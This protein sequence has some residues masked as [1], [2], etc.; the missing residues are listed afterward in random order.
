M[1]VRTNDHQRVGGKQYFE[2]E[3]QSDALVSNYIRWAT[4]DWD[5]MTLSSIDDTTTDSGFTMADG[6]F[7]ESLWDG[8]GA[9][10]IVLP[11]AIPGALTAFRFVEQ[12]DGGATITFT[13]ATGDFYAA[14]SLIIPVTN[15]G[16]GLTDQRKVIL[17]HSW[18]P[19]VVNHTG[20]AT[21]TLTAAHNRFSIA[22]TATNNQTE[23]GATLGFY[24][25]E[26]GYW[27][28]SFLGSELGDGSINAT[29]AGSTV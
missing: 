24:C 18:T 19:T 2:H 10:A 11:E 16:D 13:T 14:Q 1:G 5:G 22:A 29:F 25:Q 15:N 23:I 6:T 17:G 3:V 4:S 27:R 9:A 12:A 28:L 26:K 7:Y 20:A 8:A 21:T